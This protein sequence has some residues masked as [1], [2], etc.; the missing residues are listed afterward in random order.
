[1]IQIFN[2]FKE[3]LNVIPFSCKD[4]K[5][6]S[7]YENKV[8]ISEAVFFCEKEQEARRMNKVLGV[9]VCKDGRINYLEIKRK[10]TNCSYANILNDRLYEGR[11][12]DGKREGDLIEML[13]NGEFEISLAV[14]I[15]H[16]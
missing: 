5:N 3:K 16:T 9:G 13:L 8:K 10:K 6:L 1:M 14:K 15:R 2:K 12:E 7:V 4:M 11:S